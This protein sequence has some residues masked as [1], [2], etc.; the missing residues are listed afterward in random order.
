[1]RYSEC[2]EPI[3]LEFKKVRV[4]EIEAHGPLRSSTLRLSPPRRTIS[5]HKLLRFLAGAHTRMSESIARKDRGFLL[6]LLSPLATH[7]ASARKERVWFT[8]RKW[9]PY[10]T[11][12]DPAMHIGI[13]HFVDIVGVAS[14]YLVQFRLVLKFLQHCSSISLGKSVDTI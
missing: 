11:S 12:T 13:L 2:P 9:L 6:C 10:S 4:F 14:K 3:L 1:M 5:T 8:R 7:T